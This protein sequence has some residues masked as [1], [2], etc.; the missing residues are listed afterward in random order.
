VTAP[1]APPVQNARANLPRLAFRVGEAAA[2]LGVSADFFNAHIAGELRWIRRG[3]V[4][5]V[6]AQEL[7]GWLDASGS[8]VLDDERAA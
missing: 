8:R 7:Q 5:L 1:H 4:K 2:V 6:S 3:S